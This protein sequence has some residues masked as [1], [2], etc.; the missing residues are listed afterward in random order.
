MNPHWFCWEL[1]WGK[2]EKTFHHL[3]QYW[4][5]GPKGQSFLAIKTWQ[6]ASPWIP[7]SQE[8]LEIFCPYPVKQLFQWKP[9]NVAFQCWNSL[10][11]VCLRNRS[12]Y[13][14][15]LPECFL[16]CYAELSRAWFLDGDQNIFTSLSTGGLTLLL[17]CFDASIQQKTEDILHT[18]LFAITVRLICLPK[19]KH[20]LPSAMCVFFNISLAIPHS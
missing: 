12:E 10:L 18:S 17:V 1:A 2:T 14:L 20:N 16:I 3:C 8:D 4:C 19:P 15:V 6:E 7:S 13:D 9:I 5:M 11:K